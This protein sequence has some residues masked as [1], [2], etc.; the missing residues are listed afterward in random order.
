MAISATRRIEQWG[1]SLAVRIPAAVVR[2]THLRVGQAVEVSAQHSQVLI[3]AVKD[4]RPTLAQKL[5]A[6]DPARHD[7][8]VMATVFVGDEVWPR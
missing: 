8:E 6:F 2:S 1:N 3:K 5:T 4:P 7:R